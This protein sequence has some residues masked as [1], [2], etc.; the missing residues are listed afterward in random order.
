VVLNGPLYLTRALIEPL[1]RDR[2]GRILFFVGDGS[3]SARDSGCT[4]LSA[5][6]RG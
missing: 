4:H 1:V 3:I 6:K 2:Y 5:A